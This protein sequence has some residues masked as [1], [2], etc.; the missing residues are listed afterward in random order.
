[1]EQ[2]C[3]KRKGVAWKILFISV[4]LYRRI[5]CLECVK[6]SLSLTLEGARNSHSNTI[7]LNQNILSSRYVEIF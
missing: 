1:M 7:L 6:C 3:T 4:F 5:S 2:A